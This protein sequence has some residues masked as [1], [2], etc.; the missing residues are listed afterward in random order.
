[1]SHK[2][3]SHRKHKDHA[4]TPVEN[5]MTDA[6]RLAEQETMQ[7]EETVDAAQENETETPVQNAQAAAAEAAYRKA[8][9]GGELSPL[10]QAQKERDQYLELAQKTKAEFDNFRKRM[11]REREQ[12]KR[13]SLADFL[14]EFLG[15]FDD[16]DRTIGES[17]KSEDFTALQ[18]GIKLVRSNLWKAMEKA[19]VSSIDALGKPFDPKLHEAMTM[20]P[21]PDHEPNSVMDVF[22]TGY[23]LDDFVLRHARVI[24]AAQPPQA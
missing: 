20:V 15:A 8:A 5:E 3:H 11:A 9:E 18:E 16:L 7:T 4:S 12:L 23:M 24:V 6:D 21:S 22:Q 19:G 17:E 14:R 2:H 13:D 10:Q 1:M